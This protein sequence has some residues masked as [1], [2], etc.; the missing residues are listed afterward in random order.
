MELKEAAKAI[1]TFQY[2]SHGYQYF[3]CRSCGAQKYEDETTGEDY[4]V[5]LCSRSCPWR[6]L[7]EAITCPDC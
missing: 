2:Q 1:L 4:D 5:E 6:L 3:T 7:R